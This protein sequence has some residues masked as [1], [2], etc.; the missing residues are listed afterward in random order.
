MCKS[1][2]KTQGGTGDRISALW[3]GSLLHQMEAIRAPRW[4]DFDFETKERN[5][6]RW[7]GNGFSQCLTGGGDPSYYLNP[8][9]VDVPMADTPEKDSIHEARPYSH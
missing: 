4:E 6:L 2:Y 5:R 9:A 3:P 1:W 7:F 8:N